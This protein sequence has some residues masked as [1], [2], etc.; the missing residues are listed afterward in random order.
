MDNEDYNTQR[1]KIAAGMFS[2]A[3]LSFAC[4]NFKIMTVIIFGY[5]ACLLNVATDSR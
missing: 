1:K 5:D 3:L 2:S 4:H